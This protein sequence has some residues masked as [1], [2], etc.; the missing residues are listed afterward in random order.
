LILSKLKELGYLKWFQIIIQ[1]IIEITL[2][3]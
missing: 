1:I 2:F 3:T